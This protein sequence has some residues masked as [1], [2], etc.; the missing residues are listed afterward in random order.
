MIIV[1]VFAGCSESTVVTSTETQTTTSPTVAP[2]E[3]STTGVST[4][5]NSTTTTTTPV[6][7]TIAAPPTTTADTDETNT[8]E[9]AP[10]EQDLLVAPTAD[11][12]PP[13][14]LEVINGEPVGG[15]QRVEVELG[16]E[17]TVQVSSD[18]SEEVHVHGYDILFSVSPSEPLSASFVAD[19]PGIFEIELE[20]SG[21]LLV[22]LTVS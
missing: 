12:S 5:T 18:T 9:L 22:Q 13:I 7:S 3:Q 1:V 20:G 2:Q 21:R 6:S 10:Q 8:D 16:S 14:S 11:A 15:H 17:V 19:I 4:T